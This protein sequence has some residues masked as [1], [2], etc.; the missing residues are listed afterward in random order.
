MTILEAH[1][2]FK[3]LLDKVDSNSYPEFESNEI[4]TYLDLAQMEFVK[5]RYK[6][7]ETNTK[8][9]E[10][11]RTIVK[12]AAVTLNNSMFNST[13]KR[14]EVPKTLL[15]SVVNYLYVVREELLVTNNECNITEENYPFVVSH[16]NYN[17]VKKDPFRKPSL[18][19][20]IRIDLDGRF[21]IDMGQQIDFNKYNILYSVTF[22]KRPNKPF[23]GNPVPP[24]NA[25]DLELPEN[26]HEEIVNLAVRKAIEN[27]ESPRLQTHLN[28]INLSNS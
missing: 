20:P 17:S 22:L 8:R 5:E 4:D 24:I 23:I 14:Y 26:V 3:F 21:I 28:E 2:L 25:V 12:E 27:I 6:A 13:Y 11:L 7:F 1:N 10:D 16:D 19:K 9:R 15:F 18:K